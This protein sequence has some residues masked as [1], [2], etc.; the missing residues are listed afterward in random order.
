MNMK[1]NCKLFIKYVMRLLLKIYWIFPVQKKRIFFMANMGKGYL[2]NPKYIYQSIVMDDRFKNYK[3][4]WSFVEP[5]KKMK[6]FS[7]SRTKLV[8][9][10]NYFLD[11]YYFNNRNGNIYYI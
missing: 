8:K 5:E 9:K 1:D 4:V 11:V 3:F 2:C 6:Y 10:G 7:D